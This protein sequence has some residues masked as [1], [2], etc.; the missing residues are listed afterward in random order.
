[1][2][3]LPLAWREFALWEPHGIGWEPVKAEELDGY[4]IWKDGAEEGTAEF[5]GA[6][7]VASVHLGPPSSS[8]G[9]A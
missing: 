2:G 3:H 7:G 6:A 9:P 1:M 4:E 5:I 8:L